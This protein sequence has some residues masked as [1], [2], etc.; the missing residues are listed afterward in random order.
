MSYLLNLLRLFLWLIPTSSLVS[1]SVFPNYH[2]QFEFV[3]C[4]TS[5]SLDKLSKDSKW[6]QTATFY[7]IYPRSF[8]DSNGD[9]VGDLNG[10]KLLFF[11]AKTLLK[12]CNF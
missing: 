9:G 2:G 7:Q 5:K 4:D 11:L 12:F 6:W 3:S 1:S 10:I 8:K